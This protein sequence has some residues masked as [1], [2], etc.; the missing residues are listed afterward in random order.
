MPGPFGAVFPWA[1]RALLRRLLLCLALFVPYH[2]MCAPEMH[3]WCFFGLAS[4]LQCDECCA[5]R[6]ERGPRMD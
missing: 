3:A 4:L 1:Y 6:E 5:V 2:L